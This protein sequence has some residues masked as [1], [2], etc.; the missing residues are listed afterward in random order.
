MALGIYSPAVLTGRVGAY[1]EPVNG[2]LA[3]NVS[4]GSLGMGHT[5]EA[6]G[7][8]RLAEIVFQLRAEAGPRQLKKAKV[9]LAQSWRG[10]PTTSGAVVILGQE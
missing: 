6:S 4:G 1:D 7:L 3:V 10:V 2:K 9:G 8:Y 5:S